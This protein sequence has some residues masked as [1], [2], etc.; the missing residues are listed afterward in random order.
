MRGR[1]RREEHR[2]NTVEILLRNRIEL[3][4]VAARAS[5]SHAEESHAGDGDDVVERILFS[6]LAAPAARGSQPEEAGGDHRLVGNIV[7]FVARKLFL[8]E[9]IGWLVVVEG[10]GH[11]VAIAPGIGTVAVEFESVGIGEAHKVEPVP[12][13]SFAVVRRR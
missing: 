9:T 3:M 11:V 5:Y 2:L 1:A 13:P 4:I 7:E 8:D 6:T 12:R 10:F